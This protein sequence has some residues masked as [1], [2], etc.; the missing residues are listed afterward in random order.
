VLKE[1][2][3]GKAHGAGLRQRKNRR[4]G[5]GAHRVAAD[6][7]AAF[8]EEEAVAVLPELAAGDPCT[9]ALGEA[10]VA[11]PAAAAAAAAASAFF[12]LICFHMTRSC[13]S[14]LL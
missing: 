8:V 6:E 2:G 11:E 10:A 1:S 3:D 13:C 4:V 5:G 7:E 12:L 9:G 14:R